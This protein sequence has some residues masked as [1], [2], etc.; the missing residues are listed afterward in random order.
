MTEGISL[1]CTTQADALA[2]IG[3]DTSH[4]AKAI[5][6]VQEHVLES[7]V[8]VGEASRHTAL[9]TEQ[10]LTASV[11]LVTERTTQ[12]LTSIAG[13]LGTLASGFEA[14]AEQ[15]ATTTAVD[16]LRG[17]V[18]ALGE[19]LT[20]TTE[21]FTNQVAEAVAGIGAMRQAW[22][23]ESAQ[24][25]QT[26]ERLGKA[27]LEKANSSEYA[28]DQAVIELG[29]RVARLELDKPPAAISMS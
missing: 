20:S 18:S 27:L 22:G 24:L 29:R 13:N 3:H 6:D 5:A 1:S 26:M 17:E 28:R 2:A 25:V 16:K 4:L 19:L 21:D 12:A 10:R 7:V 9:D 23:N 14:F 11:A 8:T 15:T